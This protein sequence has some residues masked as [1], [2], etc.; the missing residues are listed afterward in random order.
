MDMCFSATTLAFYPLDM[1][2]GY[3]AAGTWPDDIVK[4][5]DSERDKYW[6]KPAPEG[7]ELGSVKGRPA[8]VDV[9]LPTHEEL[10]R[11]A[12]VKKAFLISEVK[13]ETEMLR[14]RLA[15]KRIKPDEEALLNAWFDYLDALELVDTSSA[16]DIE[17]PTPPAVQAR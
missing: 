11:Q 16:P 14:T 10:V 6:M 13:S 3:I 9:A 15:L 4:L 2:D 7:K 5:T 8:W 12:E 1:K 17:W